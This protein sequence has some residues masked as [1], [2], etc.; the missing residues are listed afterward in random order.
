MHLSQNTTG[1][2]LLIDKRV[3]NDLENI[4]DHIVGRFLKFLDEFEKDPIC[5]RPRFDVKPL[6]GLP[7]NLYRLSIGNYRVLYHVD[8]E[9]KEVKITTIAQRSQAYK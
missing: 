8:D 4:P 6:K 3:E 1:Y 5:P 2:T 7:G 9:N